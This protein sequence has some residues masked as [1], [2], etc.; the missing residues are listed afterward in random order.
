MS[1]SCNPQSH[2]SG[3]ATPWSLAVTAATLSTK[4]RHFYDPASGTW[5]PSAKVL[6]THD[7]GATATLLS[8]GKVLML[9]GMDENFMPTADTDTYQAR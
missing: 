6:G 5:A 1:V 7:S 4:V 9:G 3:P 2:C 8:I